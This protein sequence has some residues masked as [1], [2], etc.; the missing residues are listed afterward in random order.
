MSTTI[1]EDVYTACVV[2]MNVGGDMVSIVFGESSKKGTPQVTCKLGIVEGELSG[3]SIYWTGYLTDK[4]VKRTVQAL[5]ALGFTG[6]KFADFLRQ[7]PSQNVSIDVGHEEYNGNVR[8]RVKFIN[9]IQKQLEPSKIEEL[10]KQF[11]DVLG[12]NPLGD[13]ELSF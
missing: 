9:T 13:D 10:S 5:R 4:T 6:D 7:Q 12:G 1:P 8:A 2:P 3:E 11:S